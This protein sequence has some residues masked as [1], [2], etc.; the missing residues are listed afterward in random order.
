MPCSGIAQPTAG[1]RE[2]EESRKL[3]DSNTTD[4][5]LLITIPDAVAMGFNLVTSVPRSNNSRILMK[6]F[7]YWCQRTRFLRATR[8]AIEM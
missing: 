4:I 7:L 2:A 1:G 8:N 3:P 5:R 6:A